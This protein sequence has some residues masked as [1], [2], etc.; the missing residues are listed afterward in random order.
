MKMYDNFFLPV[1]DLAQAKDYYQNILELPLKFDFSD[2]GMVA[3]KVGEEEP[4]IILKD[5]NHFPE[6]KP[7]I[8]FVAENVGEEYIRLKEKGVKFLGEPYEIGTGNAV[9]FEDAFGN[10]FGIAD[11]IRRY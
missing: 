8:W 5:I 9:E 11:Y 4:A 2:K 3:F 7:T 1:N 6:A 10:R